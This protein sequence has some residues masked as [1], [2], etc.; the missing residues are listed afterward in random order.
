[1]VTEPVFR[2]LFTYQYTPVSLSRHEGDGGF[3]ISLYGN[4][5][6]VYTEFDTRQGLMDRKVFA[7]HSS[8]VTEYMTMLSCEDW[9]LSKLPLYVPKRTRPGYQAVFGLS[10]HPLFT[11]DDVDEAARL[12]FN[13]PKGHIARNLLVMMESLAQM[14][15][16]DGLYMTPHSFQW[17]QRVTCP[18][19]ESGL[20]AM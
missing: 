3:K 5:T 10:G 9:R 18:L 12:P 2:E 15:V 13:N 14:L 1:M 16:K 6:I 4:N 17:D 8:V 11:V 20:A 7:I 19:P